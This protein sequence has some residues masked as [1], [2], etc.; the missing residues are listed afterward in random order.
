VPR[1]RWFV[2]IWDEDDPAVARMRE[3]LAPRPTE[4]PERPE[5]PEAVPDVTTRRER[6]AALVRRIEVGDLSAVAMLRE[7]LENH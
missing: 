3:A 5:A 4:A 1:A 7:L 6:I 2:D